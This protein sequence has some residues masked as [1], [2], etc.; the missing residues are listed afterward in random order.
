MAHVAHIFTLCL[1]QTPD[2]VKL[3]TN[4]CNCAG[5]LCILYVFAFLSYIYK[6]DDRQR[7]VSSGGSK[8][9]TAN[10]DS[11]QS[12]LVVHTLYVFKQLHCTI[13]YMTVGQKCENVCNSY[14]F[15]VHVFI[16]HTLTTKSECIL[17]HS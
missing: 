8:V 9:F 6:Y 1:C 13:I 14:R 5:L 2:T 17:T 16:A 11:V 7:L 15:F 10:K 12:F 4:D 3:V